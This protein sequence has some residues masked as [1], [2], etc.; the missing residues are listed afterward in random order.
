MVKIVKKLIINQKGF[1]L[2]ELLVVVVIIGILAL[3]FV[4]RFLG[5][6]QDARIAQ[7]QN[8]MA[9]MRAVIEAYAASDGQGFYPSAGTPGT[10]TP[11]T[12]LSA[13]ADIAQV[14]QAGGIRWT[15]A[16]D[17][18]TDTWG[19]PY[20]YTAY[21]DSNGNISGWAIVS[22]G[23]DKHAGGSTAIYVSDQYSPTI[24]T[25]PTNPTGV[26]G[27]PTTTTETSNNGTI[28]N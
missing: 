23:P 5:Y 2:V 7:A 22:A 24:G 6:T 15:G 12:T 25:V 11:G 16:S 10:W 20:Q 26:A 4:P 9:T 17:G 14:L 19:E 3:A 18:V 28:P 13:G 27:T 8:D 21:T 1:T